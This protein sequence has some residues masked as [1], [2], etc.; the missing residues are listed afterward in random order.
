MG[1]HHQEFQ[2]DFNFR[3]VS[4]FENTVLLLILFRQQSRA[5]QSIVLHKRYYVA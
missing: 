2:I 4:S 3:Q 5:P 1:F